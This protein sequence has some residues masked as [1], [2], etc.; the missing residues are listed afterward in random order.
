MTKT[1]AR[2]A[3]RK[4]RIEALTRE[5]ILDAAEEVIGERGYA[6]AGMRD[7]AARAEI[8]V[9]ALYQFFK[10][11]EDL[12]ARLLARRG[13]ELVPRIAEIVAGDAP[14]VAKLMA[15]ADFTIGYF[16]ARPEFTRV[17]LQSSF[18][19]MGSW[20]VFGERSRYR[21]DEATDVVAGLFE[22][23][24][25]AGDFHPGEPHDLARIQSGI[26][27]AFYLSDID[28]SDAEHDRSADDIKALIRRT[29]VR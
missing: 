21:Y 15:L 29:F 11:K 27:H 6:N 3:E 14:P 7:I 12:F 5:A 24:I 4:R 22:E 23:G 1:A 9:G 28:R 18:P 2:G 19:V 8:S 20:A 25:A 16:R 10:S 17:L 26:M 13:D